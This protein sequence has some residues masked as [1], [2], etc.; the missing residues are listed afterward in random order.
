[1]I[2]YV[3]QYIM[4]VFIIIA[5]SADISAIIHKMIATERVGFYD[6][7]IGFYVIYRERIPI[8]TPITAIITKVAIT[9]LILSQHI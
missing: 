4:T 3:R 2:Y 7:F 5:I 8:N 9:L 1:M 6:K